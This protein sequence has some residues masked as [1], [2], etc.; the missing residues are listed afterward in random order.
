MINSA[1]VTS[2]EVGSCP[3]SVLAAVR[4][5]LEVS[6]ASHGLAI[7]A[8]AKAFRPM[9]IISNFD[10]WGFEIIYPSGLLIEDE[11][12]LIAFVK[13]L[14]EE[15]SSNEDWRIGTERNGQGGPFYVRGLDGPW[16]LFDNAGDPL[17]M[18]NLVNRP[19]F[20]AGI[21]LSVPHCSDDSPVSFFAVAPTCGS[22]LAS[23]N[24]WQGKT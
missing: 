19:S 9:R 15:F 16:L 12:G 2:T 6:G 22:R 10:L 4:L 13:R 24:C 17:Q 1:R 14:S 5:I 11:D 20:S 8:D 3:A 18:T 7:E 21:L 23:S